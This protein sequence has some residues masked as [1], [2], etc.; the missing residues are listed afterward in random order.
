M[1][2]SN[3][4]LHAHRGR[5]KD[6]R[7]NIG[8]WHK[9]RILAVL[10]L[11]IV[12]GT[13][14]CALPLAKQEN[15]KR[16]LKY[17]LSCACALFT[18]LHLH[19]PTSKGKETEKNEDL[20]QLLSYMWIMSNQSSPCQTVGLIYP[21]NEKECPPKQECMHQWGTMNGLGGDFYYWLLKI[22]SAEFD[23]FD[24]FKSAM[25]NNEKSFIEQ[26]KNQFERRMPQA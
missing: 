5:P 7:Y 18:F 22:S 19:L 11:C 25:N 6:W 20:H 14:Y 8:H 2:S 23:S 13:L 4:E 16:R 3:K 15:R 9:L 12:F 21:L 10:L 17:R 1:V 24:G 26:Y